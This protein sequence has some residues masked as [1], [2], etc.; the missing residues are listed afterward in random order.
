MKKAG[1]M[2]VRTAYDDDVTKKSPEPVCYG[3]MKIRLKEEQ[4]DDCT[5]DRSNEE[6]TTGGVHGG[7]HS[8]GTTTTTTTR[9]RSW[10]LNCPS[11]Q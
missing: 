8:T 6:E 10:E 5:I 2:V 3:I 4:E 1:T 9:A 7:Y 11:S